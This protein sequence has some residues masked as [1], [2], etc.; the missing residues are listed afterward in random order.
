MARSSNLRI[1]TR[2][3]PLALAQ[4]EQVKTQLTEAFPD[5]AAVLE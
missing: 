5:L 2:G 1:G 3:S 4:A